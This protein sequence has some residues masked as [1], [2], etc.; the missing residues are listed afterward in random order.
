MK[1]E[2]RSD[3]AGGHFSGTS[4]LRDPEYGIDEQCVSDATLTAVLGG[5]FL[6]IDYDW[7]YRDEPQEGSLLLGHDPKSGEAT[8]YWV[9]TW[10]NGFRG[11]FLTGE[12]SAPGLFSLRG[13][14][15]APPGPD[16]GWRMHIHM[17]E[18][19]S[20]KIVM[21]NVTPDGREELA[22]ESRY[23]VAG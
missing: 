17:V 13:S 5:R 21:H 3:F 11:M 16:W 19:N 23:D 1:S 14:Y 15:A 6:R 7:K 9:D 10:H 22:V 8:A 4:M 12:R 2:T 18:G 20:L